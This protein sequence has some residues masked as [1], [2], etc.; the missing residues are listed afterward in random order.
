MSNQLGNTSSR[1]AARGDQI[2]N[3]SRSDSPT[4][5]NEVQ[6]LIMSFAAGSQTK[7]YR[8]DIR[9]AHFHWEALSRTLLLKKPKHG[10]PDA[11]ADQCDYLLARVPIYG[12]PDMGRQV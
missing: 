8:V 12:T 11:E 1:L 2:A 9:K 7:I 10:L 3:K 5:D 6:N 4:A